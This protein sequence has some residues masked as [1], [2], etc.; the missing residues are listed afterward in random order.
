MP[1]LSD[2]IEKNKEPLLS[3]WL[4][5][6]LATYAK[7]TALLWKQQRNQFTN[8][9]GNRI[10]EGIQGI[11]TCLLAD[12][13]GSY[14]EQA[15]VFLDDI[16]RVRAVQDFKPSEAVSFIYLLKKVLREDL[17][18]EIKASDLFVELLA[19][20]SRIDSLALLSLDIYA[21]CREK[22]YAM[23]IKEVKN[24]QKRL[25][26]RANIICGYSDVQA[27]GEDRSPE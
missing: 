22:L 2:L 12:E 6:I 17:W 19:L 1:T 13:N 10:R 18:A 7:E 24:V 9:V 11:L 3:R 15:A 20:E 23:R 4:D 14:Q 21:N 27:G 5:L 8:P 25:L 16:V 26:E